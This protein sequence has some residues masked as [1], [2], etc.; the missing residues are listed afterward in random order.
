MTFEEHLEQHRNEDGSYDL[1]AAE[2]ARI[3]DLRA[4]Y[5]DDDLDRLAV[6]AAAQE[7]R[8]WEKRNQG[9]L[10]KLMAQSALSP[11]LELDVMVPLGDSRVVAYGEMNRVRIQLRKDLRTKTHIDENRAFDD[12]MTH[13]FHTDHLLEDDETIAQAIQ[14]FHGGED[15][16]A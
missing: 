13:W 16:A 1:A 3:E 7:R 10:R 6:K 9:D 5:T 15:A 12:E 14:R 4:S 2:Q 8:Q 11:E